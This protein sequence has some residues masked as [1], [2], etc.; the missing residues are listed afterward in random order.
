MDRRSRVLDTRSRGQEDRKTGGPED[1]RA[2]GQDVQ[3]E[4]KC[5]EGKTPA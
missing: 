1:R 3:K 2:D 5:Q 4:C